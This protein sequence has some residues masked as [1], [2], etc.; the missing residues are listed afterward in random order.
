M[1]R[2]VFHWGSSSTCDRTQERCNAGF[3]LAEMLVVIV[4]IAILASF[5]I[6]AALDALGQS[7]RQAVKALIQKL[8]GGLRNYETAMQT[9]PDEAKSLKV[10][11]ADGWKQI[12]YKNTLTGQSA[13]LHALL[14]AKI[15]NVKSVDSATGSVTYN[16]VGPFINFGKDEI[17]DGAKD[18]Y[19]KPLIDPWDHVLRVR[20]GGL[21]HSEQSNCGSKNNE[22]WVDIWSEGPQIEDDLENGCNDDDINNFG[23]A[24]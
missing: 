4:I 20:F 2:N 14:G 24:E 17:K 12:R 8:E 18:D 11:K 15:R 21:N 23:T 19:T 10:K 9:I 5:L 6:P 7:K 16:E 22:N 3:T 13:M 1:A